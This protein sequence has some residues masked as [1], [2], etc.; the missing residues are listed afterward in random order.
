MWIV[1]LTVLVVI[2]LLLVVVTT[3]VFEVKSVPHQKTPA[4]KDILFKEVRIP[5]KNNLFLYGWWMPHPEKSNV[6]T[7][8]LV[9]GWKRNLERMMPYIKNLHQSFNLFAFDARCHGSSD[10]DTYSSMPRFAEDIESVVDYLYS[11]HNEN[12]D[13]GVVGLSIGGAAAIYEASFDDRINKILTVGAFANPEEIMKL[14]MKSQHIPYFPFGWILLRYVE[15]K[16]RNRFSKIAPENN[17]GKVK[18]RI[19]L[20]HG[21]EDTTAPYDHATRLY[22]AAQKDKVSLL[23]LEGRGH[24][25]CHKHPGFWTHIENFLSE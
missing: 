19:L 9:H 11:K 14:Q 13:I 1:I 17:I 15:F 18:S 20:V 4:S 24:S 16:I 7:I 5:T 22:D 25:D 21:K 12:T 23:G 2:I 8:I 6:P 10:K 3:K